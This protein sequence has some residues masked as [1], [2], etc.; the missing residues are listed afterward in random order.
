MAARGQYPRP[1][2]ELQGWPEHGMCDPY[3]LTEQSAP[4]SGAAT[5]PAMMPYLSTNNVQAPSPWS[6]GVPPNVPDRDVQVRLAPSPSHGISTADRAPHSREENLGQVTNGR[7]ESDRRKT[8]EFKI[9]MAS[10]IRTLMTYTVDKWAS[11]YSSGEG[12]SRG[13]TLPP[14]SMGTQARHRHEDHHNVQIRVL[15]PG[16][17]KRSEV[18]PE[19]QATALTRETVPTGRGPATSAIGRTTTH[20]QHIEGNAQE[21]PDWLYL[22][23]VLRDLLERNDPERLTA[24][25]TRSQQSRQDQPYCA[26]QLQVRSCKRTTSRSLV[27]SMT[28]WILRGGHAIDRSVQASLSRC[29]VR[30]I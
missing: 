21:D 28:G 5:S 3:L 14:S 30:R 23:T 17:R 27:S 20:T 1:S 9:Q 12:F 4:Y 16:K 13:A 19:P 6:H 18:D 29:L 25:P 22:N 15:L 10:H 8:D 7:I 26:D 11:T 2:S 24:M